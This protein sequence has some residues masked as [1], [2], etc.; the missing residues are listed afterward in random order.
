MKAQIQ[1]TVKEHFEKEL[2]IH[3]TQPDG[4]KIQVAGPLVAVGEK[5][6]NGQI[7]NSNGPMLTVLARS[8]GAEAAGPAERSRLLR[9]ARRTLVG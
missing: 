7:R 2:R 8:A 5:P 1:E 6:I 3:R 9:R 4:K